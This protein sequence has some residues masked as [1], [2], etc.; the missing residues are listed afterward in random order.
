MHCYT[1]GPRELEP[2]LEA[3]FHISFSGVVTYPRND[4]NRAAAAVV[5]GERLLVET[6]CPYL[7][8][9]GRRGERN[10]PAFVC[11]VLERVAQVRGEG[12]G[13]LAELT[14]QNAARLFGLPRPE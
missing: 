12:V 6:D 13:T 11:E 1:F 4:E 9:Q 14:S 10:E 2:Y 5:P 3:G 8:P 7:A